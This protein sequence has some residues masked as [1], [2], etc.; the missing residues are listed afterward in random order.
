MVKQLLPVRRVHTG[1]RVHDDAQRGA[2]DL[3]RRAN[4]S[5]LFDSVLLHAE[6]GQPDRTGLAFTAATARSIA[7]GL[8]RKAV[9]WFEV[10]GADLASAGHVGL[11]TTAHPAGVTSETHITVTP[12]A[13]GSCF[14]VVF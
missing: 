1:N 2:Q 6:P 4:A 5:P 3:T 9:G 10:Y 11:R 7:H 14:V 13:T 8:G 12:A